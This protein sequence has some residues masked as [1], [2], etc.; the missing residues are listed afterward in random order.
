M[1]KLFDYIKYLITG[2]LIVGTLV[3]VYTAID[4]AFSWSLNHVVRLSIAVMAQLALI[5]M[6][7]PEAKKKGE[8][9]A[10]YKGNRD[11]AEQSLEKIDK[12]QLYKELDEFCVYATEQNRLAYVEQRCARRGIDYK[13]YRKSLAD[14]NCPYIISDSD[15]AL[16]AKYEFKAQRKCKPLN[17]NEITSCSAI[18]RYKYDTTNYEQGKER[19]KVGY[20]VIVSIF[21]ALVGVSISFA[22]AKSFADGLMDAIYW[23]GVY[24]GTIWF[25]YSTGLR[26]VTVTRNDYFKRLIDF[27]KRFDAWRD[28][29]LQ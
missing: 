11:C 1:T 3:L 12:Q 28:G 5:A 17:S 24:G 2:V 6:W 9:N 29:K 13:R 7:I 19:F 8:E 15:K 18:Q 27:F 26:L 20:K 22:F 4:V 14:E 23:L 25:S 10:V 21:T 16:I